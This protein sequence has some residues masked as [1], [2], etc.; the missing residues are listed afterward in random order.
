MT[1]TVNGT[2]NGWKG[3]SLNWLLTRYTYPGERHH[4]CIF[5]ASIKDIWKVT[6][7]VSLVSKYGFYLISMCYVDVL[8]FISFLSIFS[9]ICHKMKN[10]N[11]GIILTN[12]DQSLV[13]LWSLPILSY[14]HIIIFSVVF[15]ISIL[16]ETVV[17]KILEHGKIILRSEKVEN[18]ILFNDLTTFNLILK[19]SSSVFRKSK[20]DFTNLNKVFEGLL[21]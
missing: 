11:F 3:I 16:S 9:L 19:W 18:L 10:D 5:T 17:C 1:R 6:T 12:F 21:R 7:A 13:I 8:S 4:F 2:I 20:K 14:V 15:V